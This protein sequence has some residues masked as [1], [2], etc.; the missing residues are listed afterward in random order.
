LE[1]FVFFQQMTV[2]FDQDVEQIEGFWLK[3]NVLSVAQQ[4]PL[5]NV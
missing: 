4:H 1:Q 5:G 2:V 3:W